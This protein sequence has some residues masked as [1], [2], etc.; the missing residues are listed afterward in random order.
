MQTFI[1]VHIF[2]FH[3]KTKI[4]RIRADFYCRTDFLFY[5][6]TKISRT[7]DPRADVYCRTDGTDFFSG[8]YELETRFARIKG[9]SRHTTAV[10]AMPYAVP[11][12]TWFSGF[13]PAA[14]PFPI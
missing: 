3:A 5:T 14:R 9:D 4:G 2:L 6:I 7:H 12:T 10:W 1:A 8:V 11:D 13:T